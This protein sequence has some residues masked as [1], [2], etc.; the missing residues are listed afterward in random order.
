MLIHVVRE[1]ESIQ[2]I[3]DYYGISAARLIQDNGLEY[4]A[5][6]V[7]GQSLVI[8]YPEL[9]YTVQQGDTLVGIANSFNVSLMQL[10][11]NNPYLADRDYMYPGDI[12]VIRYNTSGRITTHGNTLPYIDRRVLKKTLPYLTYLS[13][14]N[15]TAT[16]EGEIITY[17]DD[18]EIIQMAKE[19]GVMPLML[20]TTLT[21]QGKANI[22]ITFDI[23]LNEDF[24]QRQ[25]ENILNI[26]RTKGYYGV[27]LSFENIS[28]S[29]LPLYESYFTRLAERLNDEGFLVFTTISSNI[30]SSSDEIS[31]EKVDYAVL[32]R[33]SRNIIF[34]DYQWATNTNPP[35]PITS[36]HE[37][38]IFLNYISGFIPSMKVVIGLAAIGYDWELPFAA[39]LSSVYCLT[40]ERA[41]DLARNVGAEIQFDEVSQT[42]F[43]TYMV[44]K[45]GNQLAHIV[46]FI[47]ART[48]NALLD[49]I[50]KY[51]LRGIGIWNITIYNPQLWLIINSQYEIE[52]FMDLSSEQ[53]FSC[54]LENKGP[55]FTYI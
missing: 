18:S 55:S 32:E 38:D 11:R 2:S 52:K 10:F 46:W 7:T 22:G 23:L 17:Y 26:L 6:L 24:Q 1:G 21:L 29:T 25:I 5:D 45:G 42:P 9:T 54:L 14:L 50:L 39:G 28:V 8:V 47:D 16:G 15:Y 49:L 48:I 53:E 44:N 36:I 35:S 43:F 19:C 4:P 27:N 34:M 12:I 41:V 37:T 20:L 33:L 51:A 40:P 13:I 30:T 3:A 31:F